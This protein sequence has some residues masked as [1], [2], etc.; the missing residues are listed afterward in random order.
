MGFYS[1]SQWLIF[2]F[3]YCFLGWVWECL[4]VSVKTRHWVNR[5]FL[6]GPFLPIYGF[7]AMV[8]LLS[9][10][11]VRSYVPLIFVFGMISSTV[12]EY[13]TGFAMEKLFGVKYWDYSDK[14]F[15]FRG[16]ICLFASLGW[17]LFS[18]ILICFIHKPIESV[19]TAIPIVLSDITAF[20]LG[21]Y[22]ACDFMISFN[23][24]MDLKS[25]L[26][27]FTS[28]NEQVKIIARRIEITKTFAEGDIIKLR[29]K[30]SEALSELKERLPEFEKEK[31]FFAA[32]MYER[33][34]FLNKQ[35]REY[36]H[37]HSIL[38]RNPHAVSKI[39]GE[40]FREIKG[41]LPVKFTVNAKSA[42]S[43][44][45]DAAD[46]EDYDNK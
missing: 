29:D 7:G 34:R 24:A 42:D 46:S 9:T 30:V 35:G 4:Y 16:H 27:R 36:R 8:I 14:R 45:K 21:I 26:I 39:Y 11:G 43:S 3:T 13:V 15:N 12:L 28:E 33:E 1:V 20:G 38:K 41:F 32:M 2:F 10:I 40:A 25:M 23:E 19:V 44:K 5:G 6:H 18:V 37:I 17:G 31:R 22:M